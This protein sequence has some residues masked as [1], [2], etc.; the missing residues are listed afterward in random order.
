[1]FDLSS[2]VKT[3]LNWSFRA[4]TLSEFEIWRSSPVFNVGMPRFSVRMCLMY[5][6]NVLLPLSSGL[7]RLP[8]C[9][10]IIQVLMIGG[11]DGF[12]NLFVDGLVF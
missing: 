2:L 6:Q 4:F 11:V 9:N 7:V 1:M 10:D 3:E 8:P 5:D 12:D